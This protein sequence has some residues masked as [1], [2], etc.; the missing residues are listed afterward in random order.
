MNNI[1]LYLAAV[2]IWGSTWLAITFQLGVVPSEVSVAYRFAIAS[3][4]LLAYCHWRGLNLRFSAGEHGW[5]AL[6]GLLLFGL[7]YLC[8][9]QAE[10]HI[11][12]GLVAVIFS[13][14]VFFNML[15]ARLFFGTP[16]RPATVLGALLGIAG[17][18]L[19]F[20][21]E[22]ARAAEAGMTLTGLLLALAGTLSASFGNLAAGRN[23]ARGLPVVQV[24]AFGMLYGAL[25]VGGYA[26]LLGRPFVFDGSPAYVSSLLYLALFGSVLAFGA[27]LTLLGRIGAAR[28]GYVA[29]AVPLVALLLS[30]LFEGLRWQPAMLIGL[31]LCLAG[32]VLVLRTPRPTGSP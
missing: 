16:L 8:I 12:S 6:Q 15:G 27:Y 4:M 10:G 5:M 29:V 14:M 31:A 1:G 26:A 9:Y 19:L 23:S 18:A 2:L 20:L 7:N 25:L 28:A 17:V 22:I 32:N 21:P 13:L 24:N 11:H 30:T 3:L